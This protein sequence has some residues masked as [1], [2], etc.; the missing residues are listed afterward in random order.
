MGYSFNVFAFLPVS[1]LL[2]IR[3]ENIKKNITGKKL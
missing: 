2:A 3:H 1:F